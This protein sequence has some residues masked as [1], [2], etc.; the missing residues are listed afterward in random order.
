MFSERFW[1]VLERYVKTAADYG[2]NLLYT[3]LFTPPLDTVDA[4][5]A[6]VATGGTSGDG[7][8]AGAKASGLA[9]GVWDEV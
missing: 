8:A 7:D 1:T 5:E 3:P 2:I 9:A 6:G 4:A